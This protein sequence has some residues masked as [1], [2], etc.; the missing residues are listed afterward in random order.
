MKDRQQ[1]AASSD[2]P[3]IANGDTCHYAKHNEL[4][5]ENA[6]D[7][8]DALEMTSAKT[9]NG[10]HVDSINPGFIDDEMQESRSDGDGSS[11]AP[12]AN[13]SVKS[14]NQNGVWSVAN[15]SGHV[16]RPSDETNDE[17]DHYDSVAF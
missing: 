14:A 2:T 7:D 8:N 4:D 13:G 9:P 6:Q 11:R 5:D 3:A 15:N 12:A 17:N 10:I 16:A 1:K